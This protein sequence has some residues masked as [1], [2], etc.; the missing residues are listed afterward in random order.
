MFSAT[1]HKAYGVTGLILFSAIFLM[2]QNTKKRAPA[3]AKPAPA[4]PVTPQIRPGGTTGNSTTPHSGPTANSGSPSTKTTNGPTAN[5]SGT[6]RTTPTANGGASHP[7]SPTIA[8]GGKST[9]DQGSAHAG[10]ASRLAPTEHPDIDH[11]HPMPRGAEV[12]ELGGG[13]AIARRPGGG[14]RD[15]HDAG[16]GM[17]IHHE[18]AGG[19]RVS[20]MRP[21]HSRIVAE[22]GRPGFVEHPYQF[23]GH[24]FARRTFYY[25]GRAYDRFYRDYYFHGVGLHVY[26]PGLYYSAG[27]YGWAYYPWGTPVAYAWGWNGSPWIRS[28]GFY[29]SPYPV[30]ASPSLWLTDYLIANDLQTAYAAGVEAAGTQP[31]NPEAVNATPMLTDGVKAQ[32]AL[33]VRNQIALEHAEAA[34]NGTNQ[35]PDPASGSIARMLGD[36]QPHVF[37]AGSALDVVDASGAE[38]AVSDGDVLA[39]RVPPGSNDTTAVLSML[40]SKGGK[41]CARAAN[42]TVSLDDLQE[43]QNHMRETIDR[44]M[45]QL[46]QNQ[47][48]NGLPSAPGSAT[49]PP[50]TAGYA[51]LAP[52]P[53]PNGIAEVN[54]QL[55]EADQS[56]KDVTT[57]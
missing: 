17:D 43:M 21:D 47:G 14:L 31:P 40:S 35:D 1:G 50:T 27:F 52:P 20:V 22:R 30:Y 34:E 15:V 56:E 54:Q 29:F 46:Q 5:G 36:G 24:D 9:G 13:N 39:S 55:K 25:H 57:Q 11:G 28:Y 45:G 49:A 32:I 44:G 23:H 19:R 51:A 18:L 8:T 10:E 48:K 38:C 41:E 37:V 42:V 6:G 3:P 53:D 7:P 2:A 33:E 26:A 4:K 12:H 16:R